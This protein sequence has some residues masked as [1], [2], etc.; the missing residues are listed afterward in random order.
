MEN[1]VM[2]YAME[3]ELHEFIEKLVFKPY[4][5][6]IVHIDIEDY[7][8][9]FKGYKPNVSTINISEFL[10]KYFRNLP[11]ISS[12]N[13]Q[14]TDSMHEIKKHVYATIRY[15][16]SFTNYQYYMEDLKMKLKKL[17]E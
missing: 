3:Y 10:N 16:L 7:I 11:I 5:R 4:R 15:F 1:V 9:Q 14:Y 17:Y 12:I 6:D 2:E 8:F 13:S